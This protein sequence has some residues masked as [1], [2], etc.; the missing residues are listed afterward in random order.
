[1]ARY[2]EVFATCDLER[3]LDCFAHPCYSIESDNHYACNARSDQAVPMGA[4]LRELELIGF[5][6]VS[7]EL[8]AV[9]EWVKNGLGVGTAEAHISLFDAAGKLI[10]CLHNLYV[11]R[12]M[13]PSNWKV[14]GV[15]ILGRSNEHAG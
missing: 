4:A 2:F 5:A 8:G 13:E 14:V 7:Y 12:T 9:H 1:M 3:I 11:L 15:A 6:R 10:V